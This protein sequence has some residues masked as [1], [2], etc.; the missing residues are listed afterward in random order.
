MLVR[1]LALLQFKIHC[2]KRLLGTLYNVDHLK[3]ISYALV[4]L[5]LY[6]FLIELYG[7]D[8][9]GEKKKANDVTTGG[10]QS[11]AINS[12]S[13]CS[14]REE[15]HGTRGEKSILRYSQTSPVQIS[16]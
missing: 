16:V 8:T 2:T 13:R 11:W 5:V 1:I 9:V 10:E 3:R 12:I 4:F 14:S 7:Y 15:R 6:A